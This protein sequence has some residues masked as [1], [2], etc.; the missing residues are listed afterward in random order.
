MSGEHSLGA[1]ASV[2]HQ[3]N[4]SLTGDGGDSRAD[5]VLPGRSPCSSRL[6]FRVACADRPGG[7]LI[8]L[9]GL[10]G[11]GKTELLQELGVAG[12]QV[13]DLEALARHRGSAFGAIGMP[14]QPS[15]EAFA[16]LV[17]EQVDRAD[18]SRPLWVEDEGPFIGSVGV[19]PGL[20]DAIGRAPVVSLDVPF[21]VRVARLARTYGDADPDALLTALVRS[22]RRLGAE[23][24]S[25]AAACVRR[26]DVHA[27]VACVLPWFDAAYLRRTPAYGERPVLATIQEECR[28]PAG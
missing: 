3:L 19:P 18:P 9:G 6:D 7:H 17:T 1:L 23:R 21:D 4:R 20:Q 2:V 8:V 22:R 25:E 11:S 12:E 13:L 10:A 28:V 14:P 5:V 24:A 26:G 27:A 15:H 16:R